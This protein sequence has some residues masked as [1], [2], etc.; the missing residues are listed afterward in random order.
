MT[1]DWEPTSIIYSRQ[2]AVFL[3]SIPPFNRVGSCDLQITCSL[4]Q[5]GMILD[6]IYS[7]L[8]CSL[9][10]NGHHWPPGFE[11]ATILSIAT[12]SKLIWN[13]CI[14]QS[15]HPTAW[16]TAPC[17]W[18][19]L[20]LGKSYAALFIT[21]AGFHNSVKWTKSI[22]KLSIFFFTFICSSSKSSCI[23]I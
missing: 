13:A 15:C 10:L 1:R 7:I 14:H 19:R 17:Y 6:A 23:G 20:C 18:D 8:V 11:A 9:V 12:N 2:P 5:S 4:V 22:F 21:W 3:P 16:L